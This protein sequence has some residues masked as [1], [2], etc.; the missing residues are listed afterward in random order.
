MT[1]TRHGVLRVHRPAGTATRSGA[2]AEQAQSVAGAGASM[3]RV[4]P[5]HA[6]LPSSSSLLLLLLERHYYTQQRTAGVKA[7]KLEWSQN[8]FIVHV[9]RPG[10]LSPYGSIGWEIDAN[11]HALV[12]LLAISFALWSM[13]SAM[14]MVLH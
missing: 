1:V 10:R 6:W 9:T 8:R 14:C 13:A 11:M 3:E 12:V 7:V 2:G 4:N 5:L